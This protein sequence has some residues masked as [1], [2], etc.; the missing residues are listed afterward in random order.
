MG[1][2]DAPCQTAWLVRRNLGSECRRYR[3]GLSCPALLAEL[4]RGETSQSLS[5]RWQFSQRLGQNKRAG[6]NKLAKHA[7]GESPGILS[8]IGSANLLN[9]RQVA[10]IHVKSANGRNVSGPSR[11]YATGRHILLLPLRTA[12]SALRSWVSYALTLLN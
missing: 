9:I 2:T 4:I 8:L 12:G 11:R 7:R 3:A 1:I 5:I 6:P 10:T